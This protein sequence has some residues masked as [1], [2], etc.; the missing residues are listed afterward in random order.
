MTKEEAIEI[1]NI[2]RYRDSNEEYYVGEKAYEALTM[3]VEA[4][5]KM[6]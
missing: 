2:I 5:E 6:K 1:L 4:L 3:A